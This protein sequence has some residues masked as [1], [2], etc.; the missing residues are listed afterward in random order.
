M[1]Y[2]FLVT[3]AVAM[4]AFAPLKFTLSL[5]LSIALVI[6]VVKITASRIAE[7]VSFGAAA[8]AVA[9]A[10]VLPALTLLVMLIQFKGVVQFEGFV[11]TLL[12]S[13]LFASFALGFKLS[14]NTTFNTSAT[15]AVI[16]TAV[17]GGLLFLLKPLL[18]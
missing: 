9:W 7:P 12:F 14:L 6:V 5:F 16:S 2:L 11:G 3:L 4:V 18:F 13:V 17:S 15:I 8:K 1:P 10:C